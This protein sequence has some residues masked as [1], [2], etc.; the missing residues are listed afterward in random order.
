MSEAA[1]ILT[2]AGQS[3]CKINGQTISYSVETGMLPIRNEGGDCIADMFMVAYTMQRDESRPRPVTFLCNGG[4]GS[5]S[6]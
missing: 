1:E 2:T 4:P 5:S 6:I 3:S